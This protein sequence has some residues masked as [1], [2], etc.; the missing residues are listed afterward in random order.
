LERYGS[1]RV[2]LSPMHFRS[3]GSLRIPSMEMSYCSGSACRRKGEENV[4]EGE[5]NE[6]GWVKIRQGE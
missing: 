3:K 1:W 4:R 6:G 5:R 2:E